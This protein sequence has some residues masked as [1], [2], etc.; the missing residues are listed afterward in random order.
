M[1]LHTMAGGHPLGLS[2]QMGKVRKRDKPVYIPKHCT[3]R[4][5]IIY[6]CCSSLMIFKLQPCGGRWSVSRVTRAR[7]NARISG[8]C[9]DCGGIPIDPIP[10]TFSKSP[11][12]K[13]NL[14]TPQS[15]LHKSLQHDMG[16]ESR[17]LW[18]EGRG[19]HTSAACMFKKQLLH[20]THMVQ[21]HA[22]DMVRNNN[23]L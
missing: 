12:W 19:G 2:W 10:I 16:S 4:N 14:L 3:L 6:S 7:C 5:R 17:D 15:N 18:S 13:A 9:T 20:M 23:I 21:S 1:G 8:G 11:P 22:G